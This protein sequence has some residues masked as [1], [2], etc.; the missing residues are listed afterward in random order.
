M[1]KRDKLLKHRKKQNTVP[2]PSSKSW[3]LSSKPAKSWG[4]SLI[5]AQSSEKQMEGG[6][7]SSAQWV[8]DMAAREKQENGER[9]HWDRPLKV[10]AS[11]IQDG[12]KK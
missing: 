4:F 2:N 3:K 10:K 5:P 6:S 7:L 9:E 11:G 1:K 8:V 12:L